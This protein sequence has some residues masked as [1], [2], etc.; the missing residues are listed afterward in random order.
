MASVSAMSGL[1]GCSSGPSEVARSAQAAAI[2]DSRSVPIK[3]LRS[4]LKDRLFTVEE[5]S[6]KTHLRAHVP[7]GEFWVHSE[8]GVFIGITWR[9]NDR[10]TKTALL[11]EGPLNEA[12]NAKLFDELGR[13]IIANA[14]PN[15]VEAVKAQWAGACHGYS[16][17][18]FP[19]SKWLIEAGL[20]ETGPAL[21]IPHSKAC[22][23]VM[24]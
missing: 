11:G 18:V 12:F 2:S 20:G 10:E 5:V 24:P 15:R 16:D 6:G 21:C 3:D 14:R 17:L 8:A 9:L 1:L 13:A 4:C 19:S 23:M 22:G 7:N